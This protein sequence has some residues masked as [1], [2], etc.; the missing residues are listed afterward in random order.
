MMNDRFSAQLRQQLLDTADER[1]A[2]GQLAAIVAHVAITP[3]R[4]PLVARLPGLQGRVAPFPAVVRFG[5]IAVALVL[6]AVAGAILAGGSQPRAT[7]PFEGT[8][9][10]IDPLDGSTM[11]LYVSAGATPA[12]R[13]VDDVATGGACDLDPVKRFIADGTGEISGNR[14]RAS[15]PNGGGCGRTTVEVPGIYDYDDRTDT[16]L[17]QD[18]VT[19]VRVEGGNPPPTQ[20]PATEPPANQATEPPATL[21]PLPEP[22]PGPTSADPT[23]G[24]DC[25]DLAQGGTYTRP[26]GPLT[27]T[28][29]VP[30]TPTI[31][32]QGL[33]DVFNLSGRCGSVAPIGF[34]ASTAT[35]V[36]A[37][38]CMPDSPAIAS[39]VDAVARLDTPTGD[40]ISERVDLTISG[41]PAARY[42]ISNLSTC[43]GF[44]LWGGTILGPGETGS[45]YVIDVDGVLMAIELNRDGSQSE[46]ELEEA[47]AIIASLQIAR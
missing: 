47:W 3:Q 37:D 41:H 31:P 17:D 45:I 18:G 8:W 2:E 29:T 35:T 30:E 9:T 7:T 12:V 44:G 27:V 42:D 14:L 20:Q 25:V 11:N 40:D 22:T 32:W 23:A 10:T 46:A 16:L 19:W 6:A 43:E 13:F 26:V 4:R 34:F 28:A 36:L 21:E 1:A 38:S 15:F 24:A 5:L 33:R 39:F